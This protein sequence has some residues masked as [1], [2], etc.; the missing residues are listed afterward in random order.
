MPG[1]GVRAGQGTE[2]DTVVRYQD[3]EGSSVLV[4]VDE[5][6]YGVEAVSR[7]SHRNPTDETAHSGTL[8]MRIKGT[9]NSRSAAS[10]RVSW[11]VGAFRG[12]C[13]RGDRATEKRKLSRSN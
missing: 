10:M 5:D 7:T 2:M 9:E 11:A 8:V 1:L 12:K 13:S 6:T 4:E 3:G